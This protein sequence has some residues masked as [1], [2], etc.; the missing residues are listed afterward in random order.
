MKEQPI[1]FRSYFRLAIAYILVLLVLLLAPFDLYLPIG[2][3]EDNVNWL[4]GTNGIEFLTVGSIRSFSPADRLYSDL[5][6]GTGFTLEVWVSTRN[7]QRDGLASI[8]SYAANP[9]LTNFTLGQKRE[10]LVIKLRSTETD[11]NRRITE[12]EVPHVF[13][14]L[15]DQ[16]ILMTY[17]FTERRVY[18]NGKARARAQ[19]AGGR[20]TN[21]DPSYYLSLGNEVTGNRP[22]HGKL[23]LVAIY[24]RALSEE[25]VWKNY[26]AGR[27]PVRSD[28]R[29]ATG[30]VALYLFDQVNGDR[31]LDQSGRIPPANLQVLE[32][33]P[34][35]INRAF[36]ASPAQGFDLRDVI[37][38]TI[39]FIPFGFLLHAAL[40]IRFGS[41]LTTGGIVFMVGT[42]FTVGIESLQYFSLTRFSS[43][44]DVI[45]NM[46][47]TALGI[48]IDKSRMGFTTS[49][50]GLEQTKEYM[51]EEERRTSI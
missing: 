41:S 18:V 37:L 34:Q 12:L 46:A 7:N 20:F 21:W 4:T 11:S 3:E 36:F 17:D 30:S 16:H 19:G 31:V 43:M 1:R 28:D 51:R 45:S 44:A 13:N 26:M 33:L 29:V 9:S 38:N 47:G 5:V 25:E 2:V 14:K 24:N 50:R 49:R 39:L 22:W 40:S 42:V 6:S 35:I 27:T 8:V 23:F 10:S 32:T 15:G 48:V